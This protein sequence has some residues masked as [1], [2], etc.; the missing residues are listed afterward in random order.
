LAEISRRL[1]DSLADRYRIELELGCGGMVIAFLAADLMHNR[2]VTI[3]V[4][5][6]ELG[7]SIDSDRFVREIE[8]AEQLSHPHIQPL[9]DSGAADGLLYCVMPHVEGESLRERLEREKQLPIGEALRIAREVA[10]A[11][12]YAHCRGIV[13]RDI[14]PEKILLARGEVMVADFGIAR[15]ASIAAT[16]KLTPT[17]LVLGTPSYL[18]PEQAAGSSTVDARADVYSL[19]CVLYEMLAGQPPYTGRTA[20][21]VLA[22]QLRAPQDPRALRPAVSK[23]LSQVVMHALAKLPADRLQSAGAFAAAIATGP[24]SILS[25]LRSWLKKP[26]GRL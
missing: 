3:K 23:F 25:C 1:Q 19:G 26:H 2:S 14:K 20:E 9:D 16:A 5:L 6:P 17:G 13:H 7:E 15:A 4:L 12:E 8:I 11:L 24:P 22:Q 10:G 18:S 21:I